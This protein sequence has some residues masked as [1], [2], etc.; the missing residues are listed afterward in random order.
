MF[1]SNMNAPLPL[2]K[3]CPCQ[4]YQIMKVVERVLVLYIWSAGSCG[5]GTLNHKRQQEI[6]LCCMMAWI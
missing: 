5:D 1:S 6:M 4:T 2:Q 3:C